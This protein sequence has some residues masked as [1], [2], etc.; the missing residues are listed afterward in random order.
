MEKRGIEAISKYSK[1]VSEYIRVE[2]GEGGDIEGQINDLN[3]II[4]YDN[5]QVMNAN[6][7]DKNILNEYPSELLLKAKE[8]EQAEE[9]GEHSRKHGGLLQRE[10]FKRFVLESL[11]NFNKKSTTQV[12]RDKSGNNKKFII[13]NTSKSKGKK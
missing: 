7:G 9:K 2:G 4:T 6:F 1:L 12:N 8:D 10:D 3:N 11:E 5:V 13:T